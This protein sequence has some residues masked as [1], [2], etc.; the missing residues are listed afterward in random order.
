[1]VGQRM[2]TRD[3]AWL[4]RRYQALRGE[5]INTFHIRNNNR[6]IAFHRW[7]EFVGGDVVVVA[8]LNEFNQFGYVLGF[9]IAGRWLEVLNGDVYDNGGNPQPAGNG[10]SIVASG[11]PADGLPSSAA[12]VVP[13]NG[14]LVLRGNDEK[15]PP[16]HILEDII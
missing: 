4:R 7:V 2:F 3:V 12:I 8:S 14:F 6:V 15:K 11:P 13:A 1:M 16:V 10:G 5:S 9:P